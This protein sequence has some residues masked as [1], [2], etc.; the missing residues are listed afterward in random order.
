M[1]KRRVGGEGFGA[2]G[3]DL[4]G[5]GECADGLAEEG[6]FLVLG[7]GEGDAPGGVEELDGEAGEAGS[8]AKVEEGGFE[9]LRGKLEAGEEG[10]AEVALDDGFR[11]AD[12]GEVGAGVSI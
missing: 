3:P 8:G 9:G 5:K 11:V 7:F 6:G 4:G 1:S 10:F 2:G 12:G